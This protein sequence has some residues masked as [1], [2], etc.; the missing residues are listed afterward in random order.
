MNYPYPCL[1]DRLPPVRYANDYNSEV[2][3]YRSGEYN[4]D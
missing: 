3:I 2:S 1:L 4:D